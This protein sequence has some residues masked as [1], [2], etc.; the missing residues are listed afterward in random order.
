[1]KI[2]VDS[3]GVYTVNA[4]NL[5]TSLTIAKGSHNV[6]V[7]AWDNAAGVYSKSFTIT[8]N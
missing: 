8:V 5:D 4:A 7:K 6:T 1:M 3:V 2:Y